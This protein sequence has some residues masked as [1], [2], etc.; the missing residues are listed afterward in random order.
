MTVHGGF[1]VNW[2]IYG[3]KWRENGSSREVK[4]IFPNSLVW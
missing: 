2:V 1:N 3:G 4:L